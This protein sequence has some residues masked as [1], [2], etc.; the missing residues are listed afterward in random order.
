MEMSFTQPIPNMGDASIRMRV[1]S[2]RIGEC[3]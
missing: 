1:T 3:S 2:E